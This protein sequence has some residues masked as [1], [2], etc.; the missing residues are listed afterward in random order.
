MN[1]F[2]R[3]GLKI[4]TM[5]MAAGPIGISMLALVRSA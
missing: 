3:Q 4:V 1:A 2:R 5:A